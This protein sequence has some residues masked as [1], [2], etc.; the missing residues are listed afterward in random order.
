MTFTAYADAIETHRLQVRALCAF[1][2]ARLC[3]CD[4][5]A[6]QRLQ[7]NH[8]GVQQV[9][10]ALAKGRAAR[11]RELD[12]QA[13]IAARSIQMN[14]ELGLLATCRRTGWQGLRDVKRQCVVI[15]R[16]GGKFQGG[17]G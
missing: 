10:P 15:G 5:V 7:R 14:P 11:W 12:D 4:A 16:T 1:H 3:H 9:V 2:D 13:H 17:F 6:L 8:L